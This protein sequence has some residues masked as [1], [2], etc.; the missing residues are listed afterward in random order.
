M[1]SL[2]VYIHVN[3]ETVNKYCSK[4]HLSFFSIKEQKKGYGV[5][6]HIRGILTIGK[7]ENLCL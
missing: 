6:A 5:Y 7:I 3:I 2:C 4:N 1:L